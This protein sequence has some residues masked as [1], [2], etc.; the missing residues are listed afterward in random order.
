[1]KKFIKGFVAVGLT[2]IL[3]FAY[4]PA[5]MYRD[6]AV[7]PADLPVDI[8]AKYPPV[9]SASVDDNMNA[10]AG[11]AFVRKGAVN[12]RSGPAADYPVI[13]TAKKGLH[14]PVQGSFIN[15]W[16]KVSYGNTYGYMDGKYLSDFSYEDE[17]TQPD[18]SVIQSVSKDESN[19]SESSTSAEHTTAKPDKT[20][21]GRVP[22]EEMDGFG[23]AARKLNLR[24]GNSMD[25]PVLTAVPKGASVRMK[26]RYPN[27]WYLVVYNGMSGCVDSGYIEDIQII[28]PGK[29]TTKPSEATQGKTE[30]ETGGVL[31]KLPRTPG[32]EIFYAGSEAKDNIN[33]RTEP[34][35]HASKRGVIP[36]GTMV[37][38]VGRVLN[39]NWYQIAYLSGYG[40]VNGVCLKDIM[41]VDPAGLYM[42][43]TSLTLGVAGSKRLML[44]SLAV[45]ELVADVEWISSAP[46][47]AQVS[48]QG[49]VTG[50]SPGSV[51]ITAKDKKSGKTLTCTVSV[52]EY[53]PAARIPGVPVYNQVAAGYPTGCEQF[54]MR[55]MFDFYGYKVSTQDMVDALTVSPAPYVRNGKAYGGDPAFSFIGDPKKKKPEGFG[56]LPSAIAQGMNRYMDKVGGKHQAYDITGCDE[57]TIYSYISQGIPVL[58]ASGFLP[59]VNN[60]VKQPDWTWEIDSGPNKGKSVTWWRSRH[61]MVVVGYDEDY[62]YVSDP[63]FS[64]QKRF[65]KADWLAD[66]NRVDR[67]T[68]VL[69]K[70]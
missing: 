23:I 10:R 46:A 64:R 43:K 55:I 35:R 36:Q 18:T 67:H 50:I 38:I 30:P 47:I 33:V 41:E 25:S 6:S 19:T 22:A 16:M 13:G 57:E 68:V 51:L 37:R 59:S 53:K 3:V 31:P 7:I 34:S 9:A 65:N 20:E 61:V 11:S 28:P 12:I 32:V 17:K 40:Y 45:Q 69:L 39:S 42:N 58:V 27:G 21:G 44:H 63:W 15:G 14:I 26:G 62:V 52:L 48:R 24:K 1:M 8:T 49:I 5:V 54:S 66:W 2:T 60:P 4:L 56:C 29:R 70:K